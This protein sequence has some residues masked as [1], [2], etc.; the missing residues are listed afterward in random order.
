M[1][2]NAV[3]QAIATQTGGLA[4]ANQAER[5]YRKAQPAARRRNLS[6][7]ASQA[8]NEA[9]ASAN[10]G[11]APDDDGGQHGKQ[12]DALWHQQQ[13]HKRQ[14]RL[15]PHERASL[16]RLWQKLGHKFAPLTTT[17]SLQL[18]WNDDTAMVDVWL[19]EERVLLTLTPREVELWAQHL[20]Q[21]GGWLADQV[22]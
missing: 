17:D 13:R 15:A 12:Y 7:T 4:Q 10:V 5:V 3:H 11:E 14:H 18:V 20:H 8:T 9:V 1:S 2:F 16:Q 22:V 6:V 19:N 21:P